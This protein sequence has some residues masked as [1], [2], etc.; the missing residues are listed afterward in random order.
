M[1]DRYAPARAVGNFMAGDG[2]SAVQDLMAEG[3][4]TLTQAPES[5]SQGKGRH[6]QNTWQV[7][8]VRPLPAS[9]D[10]RGRSNVA[11]AVWDGGRDEVGARKMRSVWV[12]LAV[13]EGS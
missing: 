13:T 5:R 8:V 12:P 11:F 2:K 7:V 4:G 9:L 1:V 3:P 10:A 6:V